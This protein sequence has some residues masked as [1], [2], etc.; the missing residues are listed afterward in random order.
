[1]GASLRR[2]ARRLSSLLLTTLKGKPSRLQGTEMSEET[3]WLHCPFC[4][5]TINLVLSSGGEDSHYVLCEGCGGEG[6][7]GETLE[8]SVAAWNGR[9][10]HAK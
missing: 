3:G 9:A 8:E 7:A 5:E 6:G 1:M 10:E 2:L 4:G